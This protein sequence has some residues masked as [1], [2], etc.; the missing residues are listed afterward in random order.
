[1]QVRVIHRIAGE[2]STGISLGKYVHVQWQIPGE[3]GGGLRGSFEPPF[4]QY[5]IQKVVDVDKIEPPL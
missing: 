5:S 1:M 2:W 3:G 4:C